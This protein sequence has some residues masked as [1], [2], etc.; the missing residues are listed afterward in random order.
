MTQDPIRQ[1]RERIK[2]MV[3]GQGFCAIGELAG[4]LL[5]VHSPEPLPASSPLWKTRN[6]IITPHTSCDDPRY[7]HFLCDT[8]FAN[9]ARL[10]ENKPLKNRV[11]RTLGY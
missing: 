10:L 1:R 11:D 6:L 5:D 2:S 7:M 3:V 4:A 8:W 9:F